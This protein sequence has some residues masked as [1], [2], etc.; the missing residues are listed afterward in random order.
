[1]DDF[2]DRVDADGIIEN[3]IQGVLKL[4]ESQAKTLLRRYREIRGD[5]R[6]R[7]D[8]V[9]ADTFTA[10]Q[11]RGVL[12]Q[13][14][15]AIEAMGES[16]KEGMGESSSKA[17]ERGIDDLLKEIRR[18]DQRFTGAV[19]PI[20]IN[21]VLIAEDVGNL[22]VSKYE[23]SIDA[24]SSQVRSQISD[25]LTN[26]AIEELPLSEVVGRLGRFLVGEEWKLTQI[27]R[28]E[29]HNVYNIGKLSSMEEVQ[30]SYLP[31]LKKT[32]IHPMDARTGEDSKFAARKNLIVALDEPFEYTWKGKKRSFMTPPDRPND[33]SILVPYR[34]GWNN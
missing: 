33:R 6:D 20:N 5:L 27:A 16:L 21:N 14:D 24:Y 34:D 7:L 31:D 8:T 12:A 17:A 22:L 1:M 11:L 2:F 19:T 15:L 23:T 29:L 26:A 4:E 9:R 13:V 28:T 32:L 3:H 18:F 30:G 10:Q 25:A